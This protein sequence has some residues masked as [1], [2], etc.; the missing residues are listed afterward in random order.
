MAGFICPS[1]CGK[2]LETTKSVEVEPQ[3]P[4]SEQE[5]VQLMHCTIC[6]AHALTLYR[7]SHAGSFDSE[8]DDFVHDG[9]IIDKKVYDELIHIMDNIDKLNELYRHN[10]KSKDTEITL[11]NN[12]SI[13][14]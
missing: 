7:E 4:F 5:L 2:T 14:V 1:G 10:F 6:D 3:S 13:K 8:D 9:Y 11:A 12:F